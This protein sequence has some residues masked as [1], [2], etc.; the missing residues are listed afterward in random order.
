MGMRVE[1]RLDT[2]AMILWIA[3]CIV[4]ALLAWWDNV[5]SRVDPANPD[6]LVWIDVEQ[7]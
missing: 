3:A 4:A 7:E 5:D 2:S 1:A 6:D